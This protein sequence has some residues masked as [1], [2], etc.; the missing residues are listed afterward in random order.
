MNR[1]GRNNSCGRTTVGPR[2]GVRNSGAIEGVC[3][4]STPFPGQ[5]EERQNPLTFQFH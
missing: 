3:S 4:L 5:S 1:C 2:L